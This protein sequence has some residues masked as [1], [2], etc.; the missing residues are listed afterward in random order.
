MSASSEAKVTLNPLQVGCIGNKTNVLYQHG[1]ERVCLFPS[2]S[3]VILAPGA[4]YQS[5]SVY[6]CTV[7]CTPPRTETAVVTDFKW[8]DDNNY[9]TIKP[10][11][12]CQEVVISQLANVM[13][14]VKHDIAKHVKVVADVK[15]N[16]VALSVI[17]TKTFLEFTTLPFTGGVTVQLLKVSE[18]T[19]KVL[20]PFGGYYRS[21]LTCLRYGGPGEIKMMS[22]FEWHSIKMGGST[23]IS[24]EVRIRNIPFN[25]VITGSFT[26]HVKIIVDNEEMIMEVID[27]SL[28]IMQFHP[29]SEG[30]EV[31]LLK[32]PSKPE[33]KV[34][35]EEVNLFGVTDEILFPTGA[36]YKSPIIFLKYEIVGESIETRLIHDFNWVDEDELN[37]PTFTCQEMR[38]AT[39]KI[40][41]AEKYFATAI[42]DIAKYVEISYISNS[43]HEILMKV[44]DKTTH[45]QFCPLNDTYGVRISLLKT[46]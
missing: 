5:S 14:F 34:E 46:K 45:L 3:R 2:A 32:I 26:K 31:S 43:T 18:A 27:T 13:D 9:A 44:V 33:E 7:A 22:N 41:L 6:T 28:H 20:L 35:M 11:F 29:T 42:A 12:A 17:D 23:F 38:I 30:V 25:P 16:K 1:L 39:A 36:R 19:G 21:P 40:H 8:T 10:D 4:T 37:K 24:Q 15:S